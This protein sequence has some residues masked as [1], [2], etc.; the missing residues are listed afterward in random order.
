MFV[1]HTEGK[2]VS[3]SLLII[4]AAGLA[5][6]QAPVQAPAGTPLAFEVAS[7]KPAREPARAGHVGED[8]YRHED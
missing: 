4:A 7:I 2:I 5:W 6:A 1:V 3:K 8:A